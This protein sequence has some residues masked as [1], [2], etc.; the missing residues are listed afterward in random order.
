MNSYLY[1]FLGLCFDFWPASIAGLTPHTNPRMHYV[2]MFLTSAL[3]PGVSPVVLLTV[4]TGLP[5]KAVTALTLPSELHN[6]EWKYRS[7]TVS[8]ESVSVSECECE[9]ISTYIPS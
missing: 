2:F 4:C 1:L 6:R 5:S 7:V 9:R 8:L 3:C